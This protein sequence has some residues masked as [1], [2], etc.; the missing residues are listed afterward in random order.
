LLRI[1]KGNHQWSWDGGGGKTLLYSENSALRNNNTRARNQ[2]NA[3]PKNVKKNETTKNN[4]SHTN[5][6][7]YFCLAKKGKIESLKLKI[8]EVIM[9]IKCP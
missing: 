9:I 5:F 7:I 4:V 3:D 2:N 6:F 8:S 1:D